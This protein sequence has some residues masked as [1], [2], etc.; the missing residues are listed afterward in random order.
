MGTEP[1][2]DDDRRRYFVRRAVPIHLQALGS[3][4]LLSLTL[5][6]LSILIPWRLPD[7]G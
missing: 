1:V 5:V 6:A 4:L 2:E 7:S 3:A